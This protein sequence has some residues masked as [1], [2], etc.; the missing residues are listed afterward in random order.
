MQRNR[1]VSSNEN[2]KFP[3][4]M[5]VSAFLQGLTMGGRREWRAG[6]LAMELRAFCSLSMLIVAHCKWNVQLN[7]I[8]FLMSAN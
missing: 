8:D 5:H 7:Q 4:S 3:T 2:E 6:Y 1:N